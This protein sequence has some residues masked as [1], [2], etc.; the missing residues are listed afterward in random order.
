M[1]FGGWT[2]HFALAQDFA[3]F[4]W[5][6]H[7]KHSCMW[8]VAIEFAGSEELVFGKKETPAAGESSQQDLTVTL[9]G[10]S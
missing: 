6:R 5:F 3:T 9:S 2:L 4:G 10:S 7:T 1:S 8:H